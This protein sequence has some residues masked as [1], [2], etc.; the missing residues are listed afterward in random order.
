MI[1]IARRLNRIKPSPSSMASQRAR[2]LRAQGRD[3]VSLTA[4]EPDFETP[5]HIKDAAG[6]AMASGE[7]R[8]TDVGGTP[9]LKVAVADK[10][11]SENGLA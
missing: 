11:Q 3:I 1:P 8:C 9:A 10:F 5:P 2:E 4:G 6:R 7:T